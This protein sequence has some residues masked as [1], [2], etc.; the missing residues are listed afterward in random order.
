MKRASAATL[1]LAAIALAAGC[2]SDADTA[3]RPGAPTAGSDTATAAKPPARRLPSPPPIAEVAAAHNERAALLSRL[4]SRITMRLEL[5]DDEGQTQI[6]NT[7]GFLQFVQPSRVSL[8]VN[9]LGETYLLLG[10]DAT[11]YWWLDLTGDKTALYGA[12]AR[13]TPDLARRFGV[14][15]H[16][17]DML[18]LL[19]V[20]PIDPARASVTW[21]AGGRTV[22]VTSPPRAAG[23]GRRELE[24]TPGRLIPVRSRVRDAR[25]SVVAEAELSD[26][27][28]IT[29]REGATPPLVARTVVIR[30]P[31]R[32]AEVRLQLNVAD[33]RQPRPENF[34]LD[35]LL[36]R[37]N[38]PETRRVNL[39]ER[40]AQQPRQAPPTPRPAQPTAPARPANGGSR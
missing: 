24:F 12:H 29:L 31:A 39:D 13:A 11:R 18:D 10:C 21:G 36:K 15:M 7:E 25:G 34:D 2:R 8:M 4:W 37:F 23:W 19:A 17:L 32:R 35:G 1:L 26:H 16:P 3:P 20:R 40:P 9:K 22:L 14:P 33:N 6:E 27:G 28:P 38:V 5:V 30:I